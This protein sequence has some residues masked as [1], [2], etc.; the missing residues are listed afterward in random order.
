MSANKFT[1][2]DIAKIITDAGIERTNAAAIALAI[3]KAMA[4][5]LIAGDGIELRGLGSL[6]V[7]ERKATTKRNPQTGEAV[8]VPPCRR[9]V[10]RPGQKLKAALRSVPGTAL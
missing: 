9:V 7:R 8:I 1:R 2:T 4:G 3:V 5:A 10:F 6:E